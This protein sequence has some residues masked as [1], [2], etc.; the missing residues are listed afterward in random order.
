[1]RSR[2]KRGKTNKPLVKVLPFVI[3]R[4]K[5]FVAKIPTIA[6]SKYGASM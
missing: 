6:I 2:E 5:F 1:M 4:T 3:M